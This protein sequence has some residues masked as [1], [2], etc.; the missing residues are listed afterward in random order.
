MPT[1]L[2]LLAESP[3]TRMPLAPGEELVETDRY[4]L[5]LGRGDHPGWTVVQQVRAEPSQVAEVLEEVRAAVRDRGRRAATWEIGNLSTRPPDLVDRL[6][7]LGLVPD[8]EPFAV[9]MVLTDLPPEPPPGVTARAVETFEEYQIANQIMREAF[10]MSP[11][12]IVREQERDAERWRDRQAS[13]ITFLAFINGEP[14]AAANGTMADAGAILF[15]GATR[16]ELRGKGAYRALIRA[17]WDEAARHGKAALVTQAGHMSR[18][19]LRRLGFQEVAEI[20]MLRD[21][22]VVPTA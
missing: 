17:R 9:G 22:H 15:G 20:H 11:E 19:I 6:V 16:R 10:G 21:D 18:P 3:N 5:W 8:D 7:E 4:A 2:E 13:S 12:H 14:A 1:D